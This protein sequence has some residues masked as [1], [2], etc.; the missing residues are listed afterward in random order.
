MTSKENN[1]CE[2][3]NSDT[4]DLFEL[5]NVQIENNKIQIGIKDVLEHEEQLPVFNCW[6]PAYSNIISSANG[7]FQ[8][9]CDGTI[10]ITLIN[11]NWMTSATAMFMFDFNSK[12]TLN[13]TSNEIEIKMQTPDEIIE[14]ETETETDKFSV[15]FTYTKDGVISF[16]IKKDTL[17]WNMKTLN[18]SSTEFNMVFKPDLKKILI[19]SGKNIEALLKINTN[20]KN[21]SSIQEITIQE[22]ISRTKYYKMEMDKYRKEANES[23]KQFS[24]YKTKYNTLRVQNDA[25]TTELTDYSE[26]QK[27]FEQNKI[28]YQFKIN[29]L[30]QQINELSEIICEHNECIVQCKKENNELATK[31]S[32]SETKHKKMEEINQYNKKLIDELYQLKK[33][34]QNSTEN[35]NNLAIVIENLK[36]DL[37]NMR[38]DNIDSEKEIETL[39]SII[40]LKERDISNLEEIC[41]KY[42]EQLESEPEKQAIIIKNLKQDRIY[43]KNQLIQI[44]K[45]YRDLYKIYNNYKIKMQ[46]KLTDT[47]QQLSETDLKEFRL[48]EKETYT[49]YNNIF[50][51][52]VDKKRMTAKLMEEYK[53]FQ[54]EIKLLL[55]DVFDCSLHKKI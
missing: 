31:Y 4:T 15:E 18:N 55:N 20:Y 54:S 51:V 21:T 42:S 17:T 50:K 35:E 14:T 32:V 19:E 40:N 39:N 27:E 47:S 37:L 7:I 3:T 49:W 12:Q 44:K 46:L 29:K 2:K 10:E 48:R 28:E 53:Q 13:F 8:T 52:G 41:K 25:L 36:D 5:T 34:H 6:T 43:L 45:K 1:T 23:T 24:F 16:P 38:E 11:Q 33:K 9:E 30:N 26:L 22:Y